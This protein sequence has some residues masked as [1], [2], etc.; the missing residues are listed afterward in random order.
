MVNKT[1]ADI[2]Q[3]ALEIESQEHYE[4]WLGWTWKDVRAYPNTITSMVVE[5][6]V[7]IPFQS[8]SQTCY[9][10]SNLAQATEYVSAASG[11]PSITEEVIVPKDLFDIIVGHDSVKSI[12][13]LS[14]A[15]DRP[16][17][18]LLLGPVA[19]AKS[20]FTEELARLPGARLALGGSSS[21]AGI[22]DYL[23]EQRPS[24][25]ILDEMDKMS[26]MDAEILL[27]VME[28]GL[29]TRMKKNMREQVRLNLTVY[30]AANDERKISDPLK[31]RFVKQHLPTYSETDYL[32]VGLSV[33]TRRERMDAVRAK[34]IL[35]SISQKT[36][37]LRDAVKIARLVIAGGEVDEVIKSVLP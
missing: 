12:L 25:L 3:R 19:T 1:W 31:S 36:R 4:G 2:L 9:K 27:T 30:G 33:L 28:T 37:D 8:R 24:V 21:R 16:V 7:D 35:D 23:I 5:G 10:I 29:V 11:Q 13:N 34:S 14:I 17:H 32:E 15:S 20:L 26:M 6:L 22:L 18:V